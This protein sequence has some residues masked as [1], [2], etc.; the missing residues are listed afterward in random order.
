M[1]RLLVCVEE[2]KD[3]VNSNPDNHKDRDHVQNADAL[4]IC[5]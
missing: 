3:I 5:I 2:D 1:H 4:D